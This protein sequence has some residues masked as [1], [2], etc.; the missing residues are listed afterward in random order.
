MSWLDPGGYS[1]LG[2]AG[3]QSQEHSP[4]GRELLQ[5][6][7]AEHTFGAPEVFIEL[8]WWPKLFQAKPRTATKDLVWRGVLLGVKKP[9]SI[10]EGMSL[11]QAECRKAGPE[12]HA[13]S[14]LCDLGKVLK[15]FSASVFSSV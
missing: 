3:L 5:R 1:F 15:T 13:K 10:C 7:H 8:I 4:P 6:C 9:Q 14:Q 12:P 11:S 2:E